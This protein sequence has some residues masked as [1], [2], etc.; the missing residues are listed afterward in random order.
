MCALQ[1]FSPLKHSVIWK[2]IGTLIYYKYNNP[3]FCY[4]V[5]SMIIKFTQEHGDD[6]IFLLHDNKT[7]QQITS[8]TKPTIWKTFLKHVFEVSVS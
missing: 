8:S 5:F 7:K 2:T 4:T 3:I 6:N 1:L